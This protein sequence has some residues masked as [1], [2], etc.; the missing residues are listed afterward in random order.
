MQRQPLAQYQRRLLHRNSS[1]CVVISGFH[2]RASSKHHAAS[3]AQNR[4]HLPN[5]TRQHGL[6][7]FRASLCLRQKHG[8]IS[9]TLSSSTLHSVVAASAPPHC[10]SRGELS[11]AGTVN[12]DITPNH[13]FKQFAASTVPSLLY[14]PLLISLAAALD[15]AQQHRAWSTPPRQRSTSN[16]VGACISSSHQPDTGLAGA[17]VLGK[18]I[19]PCLMPAASGSSR[20]TE[21]TAAP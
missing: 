13:K 18:K 2:I 3:P 9:T 1:A 10:R 6:P 14:R 12:A 17:P 11:R 5:R 19:F 21:V 8:S 7:R 15:A 20:C 16:H 4:Q